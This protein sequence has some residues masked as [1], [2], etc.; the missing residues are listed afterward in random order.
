MDSDALSKVCN[1][2]TAR[3]F[4]QRTGADIYAL[5]IGNAWDDSDYAKLP[6]YLAEPGLRRRNAFNYVDARAGQHFPGV[7]LDD[8][9]GEFESL[10]SNRENRDVLGFVQQHGRRDRV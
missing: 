1:E 8:D 3:T 9:L 6:G 4:A 5:R 10:M 7:P 2:A